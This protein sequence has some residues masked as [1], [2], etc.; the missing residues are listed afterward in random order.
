MIYWHPKYGEHAVGEFLCQTNCDRCA[1]ATKL[2]HILQ[3]DFLSAQ[4]NLTWSNMAK[5]IQF[6]LIETE[7]ALPFLITYN[8]SPA[9]STSQPLRRNLLIQHILPAVPAV[10]PRIRHMHRLPMHFPCHV[11]RQ[12]LAVVDRQAR[13]DDGADGKGNDGI[14]DISERVGACF[15]VGRSHSDDDLGRDARH[16]VQLA[17]CQAC[18]ESGEGGLGEA[19]LEG[20]GGDILRDV[21]GELVVEDGDEDGDGDRGST[22]SDRT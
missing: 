20:S 12:I 19:G 14:P 4:E 2:S 9:I 13:R 6:Q 5:D 22:A 8:K 17:C 7:K 3:I 15:C 11:I 16:G 18:E 1:K 10:L 21:L